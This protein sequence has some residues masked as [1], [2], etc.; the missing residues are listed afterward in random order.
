MEFKNAL[1]AGGQQPKTTDNKLMSVHDL[2][3]YAIKNAYYTA[4]HVNPVS[5]L[6]LLNKEERESQTESYEPFTEEDLK[7]LFEPEAYKL[8]MGAEPDFYW[9]PLIGLHTGMRISEATAIKCDDVRKAPNGVDYIFVPKSKSNAGKRN[10]PLHDNL[11]RLGFLDFVA[12]QKAAGHARLFPKRLLINFSYSKELSTQMRLLQVARGI[13]RENDHK[14]FHS[15]RVNVITQLADKGA[16]T[17]QVM[18]IVGHKTAGM[19][20]VHMGYVRE[21]PSLKEVVD[22]LEWPIELSDLRM[23]GST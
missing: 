15:F 8:V 21:L 17:A 3:S 23:P 4:S 13:K 9:C 19:D 16:N 18:K 11:L 22:R 6:F 7:R 14:S 10:V 1:T 20:K 5:G 12:A 2:F